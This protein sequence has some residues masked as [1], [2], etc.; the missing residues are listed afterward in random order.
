MKKRPKMTLEDWL[1]ILPVVLLLLF[2]WFALS[3]CSNS[4]QRAAKVH[5]IHTRTCDIEVVGVESVTSGDITMDFVFD[6][7]CRVERKLDAKAPERKART[8]DE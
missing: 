1:I 3:S 8:P 2:L 5:Y 7:E 6:D 4:Q